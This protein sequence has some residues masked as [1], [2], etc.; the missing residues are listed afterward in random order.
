MIQWVEQPDDP[1]GGCGI[2]CLAMLLGL[3]YVQMTIAAPELCA[4]CGVEEPVMHDVLA[5]HGYAVQRIEEID[6]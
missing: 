4:K 6:R 1:P 2:A 5:E 3:N